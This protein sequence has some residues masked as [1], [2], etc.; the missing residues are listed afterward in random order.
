MNVNLPMSGPAV[1][2]VN[3]DPPPSYVV[4]VP[5]VMIQDDVCAD[6]IRYFQHI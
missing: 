5:L 4:S 6:T 1:L 2:W 3:P